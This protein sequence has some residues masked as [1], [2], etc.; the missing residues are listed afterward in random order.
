MAVRDLSAAKRVNL[1]PPKVLTPVDLNALEVEKAEL[2]TNTDVCEVGYI[3]H[4]RP[5]AFH[6]FIPNSSSSSS[7]I[8]NPNEIQELPVIE[9][10]SDLDSI[11][12]LE[13]EINIDSIEIP[14]WLIPN[15][16]LVTAGY[17]YSQDHTRR[18]RSLLVVLLTF[19]PN[20]PPWD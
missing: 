13:D 7:D 8:E 11:P 6:E 1:G 19:T 5:V 17:S 9:E 14:W 12:E 4:E 15:G 10:D 3:Q 2:K 20:G 18:V 16:I